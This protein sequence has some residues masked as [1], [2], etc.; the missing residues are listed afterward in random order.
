MANERSI[1]LRE[2]QPPAQGGEWDAP[3]GDPIDPDATIEITPGEAP[4]PEPPVARRR[5]RL[6]PRSLS[7]RLVAFVVGLVIV[8]VTAA[9]S[10]TYFALKSFLYGRLD[11]QVADIADANGGALQTCF[12]AQSVRCQLLANAG[13]GLRGPQQQWLAV[14]DPTGQTIAIPKDND[15][16]RPLRLSAIQG[17]SAISDP[18]NV[19]SWKTPNGTVRAAAHVIVLLD[20][21][22][23]YVVTGLSTG[24]VNRTLHRLV[25]IEVA[26]GALAVALALVVT[27]WGVHLNLRQLNRVTRTAREVTAELSPE[28]AGLD[29]RVPVSDPET[30][31]GQLGESF[32]TLMGTVE[33][34]FAA[35][36]ESEERMRQFLADA[37]HELRTPLT[38]IRGYAELSRLRRANGGG[39]SD[40]EAELSD[41]LDRIE[42]E[43]TR[44]SRLVED[45]LLLARSD[46]GSPPH[47]AD[48]DVGELITDAV[49]GARAAYPD[50]QIDAVAPTGLSVLADQDQ[51]LR[52]LRNLINNA[53]VH[54]GPGPIRVSGQEENGAIALRVTDSGPG[55]PPQEA[56]HVFERFW[57]ADKAR[58]R[59]RGG[60]GLG[61][62]IVAS[63]VRAHGGTVGFDSS[64][65]AGSTVTVRLPKPPSP[66]WR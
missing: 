26:I 61:L 38:S 43:G 41:T 16:I 20:G 30:E 54:T 28:G 39:D 34:Q 11:Q 29:R 12:K 37:S 47:W 6:V 46:Q 59:A 66:E 19:H 18:E 62:S 49:E 44:M 55:L 25:L 24:E 31:V 8:V 21:Q 53:A 13:R 51:L 65:A 64:V 5:L 1:E 36:V 50:R 48:V 40:G 58:S 10:A 56:Q 52:V 3:G 35:R 4:E 42:S 22:P 27:S 15:E 63:I 17:K 33:A 32:N 23:Y 60:S 45:L 2:T 57:R 14:L 7:S 9:G